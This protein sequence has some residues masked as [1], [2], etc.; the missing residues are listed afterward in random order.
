VARV[1]VARAVGEALSELGVD[2]AFGLL[3]SG[4]YEVTLALVE[5][6]ARF[7]ATRHECAAITAAD[8]Y[9]R[10]T[11]QVGVCSVHQGPGLTNTV[12]GLAEAAKSRTPL[13]VLAADVP[14]GATRSNFAIG[15]ALLAESVGAAHDRLDSPETAVDDV[16]RAWRRARDERRPVVLGMPI[17]VQHAE[18]PEA[19]S[20]ARPA[21]APAP[22][23]PDPAAVRQV[24]GLLDGARRPLLIAGRG[25]VLAGAG[26]AIEALAEAS[27]ALLATSAVAHGL[28]AASPWSLGI[29][30]GFAT[31]LALELI[32]RA[33]VVVSFGATLNMWTTRHGRLL[34]P[35]AR[36]A[37][38]DLDPHAIGVHRPAD[39]GVAG[40]AAEAARAILAALGPGPR[41][42]WRTPELRKRIAGGRWRDQPYE[43]AGDASRIDPRTLARTLDDLLPEERLIAV[44]SGHFMGW[45]PMYCRVPDEQG[46]V[47]TQSFQS[48]GLG[49]ATATG[50]AIAR[51]DRLTVA[52]L[53]DGGALMS[54][55]ELETVARLGLPMLIV[56]FN[57]AAY[58]AEVHHF[59][60]EGFPVDLVR[61]PD[62]DFAALA[63]AAGAEGVTVRSAGDLGAVERW[64]GD[65]RR[66]LLVDAR[67]VP[68]VVAEWLPEAFGH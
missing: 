26:P 55:P 2:H 11:G 68:A 48:I 5:C 58:A 53:G 40:D 19:R 3:G 21:P 52:A 42:G 43:D 38:V 16:L 50:A 12:T 13:L 30:G 9:S 27:G 47:M 46:F 34:S 6:G 17:D 32:P 20:A 62:T 59:G 57:D 7:V 14:A 33:D 67:I 28:F 18:A 22:A 23:A 25:A 36:L 37:Q 15:Q 10:L 44:D 35:G 39:A 51:P 45:M 61:F 8:A 41:P 54:L 64:L 29:S 49:L 63:R 56:V 31:P 24:A 4:N 66:P 60:P 1:S 65:R